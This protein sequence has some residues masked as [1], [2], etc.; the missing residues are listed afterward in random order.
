MR[1]RPSGRSWKLST[2]FTRTTSFTVVCS[3]LR[4]TPS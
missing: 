3:N 1:L 4:C 2:I